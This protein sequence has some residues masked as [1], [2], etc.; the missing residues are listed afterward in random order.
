VAIQP[1]E[2]RND[3]RRVVV[4]F[5]DNEVAEGNTVDLDLDRPQFMLR[6]GSRLVSTRAALVPLASVKRIVVDSEHVTE[7]IPRDVV[8]K[9]ALH[10]WDGEVVPG[11]LRD[12]PQR[13][14]HGMVL[15]LISP[16]ADRAE[17]LAVPYH[18]LKAVFFLR[19]WDTRRPRGPSRS[20]PVGGTPPRRDAPLID[21]LGEIRGLRGLRHRGQ[22]SDV[23]YERR[24]SQVLNRI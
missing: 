9:V 21:L 19:S 14:R 7:A 11:L 3:E 17:V 5:A 23:E 22:I 4:C 13:Q 15:E 24:R 16:H 12:V 18:A 20:R 10:F 8:R 6:I 1:P 2:T